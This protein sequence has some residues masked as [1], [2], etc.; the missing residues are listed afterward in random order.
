M[1]TGSREDKWLDV[2][3]GP[4]AR[5]V[6]KFIHGAEGIIPNLIANKTN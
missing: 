6:G 4:F 3:E 2:R 5:G 1:S